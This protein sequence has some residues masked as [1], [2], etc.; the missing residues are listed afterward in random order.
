MS[1]LVYGWPLVLEI[2]ETRETFN[3][4]RYCNH[5]DQV[6]MEIRRKEATGERNG[7]VKLLDDNAKPHRLRLSTSHVKDTLGWEVVEHPSYSP[8]QS[9]LYVIK[10][11]SISISIY[12]FTKSINFYISLTGLL[13]SRVY[14]ETTHV[15]EHI[16][17]KN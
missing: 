14:I 2:V 6:Q 16:S 9:F 5:L 10:L 3:S 15:E 12:S 1:Q 13:V 7:P 4:E 8:D 11:Y 17:V